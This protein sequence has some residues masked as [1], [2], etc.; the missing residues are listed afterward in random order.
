MSPSVM[1]PSDVGGARVE[2]IGELGEPGG[3]KLPQVYETTIWAPPDLP[4]F[5]FV[6]IPIGALEG[7]AYRPA[8]VFDLLG[9]EPNDAQ[10][11]FASD[12]PEA[13]WH[14]LTEG[15]REHPSG[16][17]EYW[18]DEDQL[19]FTFAEYLAFEDLIPFE[20]SPQ[21]SE[22]GA[23][24]MVRGAGLG[25]VVGAGIGGAKIGATTGFVIGTASGPLV[26]LTTG[27]GFVIGGVVGAVTGVLGDKAA[28]FFRGKL[29]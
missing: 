17:R 21:K 12:L 20:E 19:A 24:L 23:K 4:D 26:V 16:A 15:R 1:E 25:A 13:L 10:P 22:S 18:G 7:D 9:L 11:I 8:Q 29:A 28:D 14:C 6:T 3:F 5:R 27:A 2:E